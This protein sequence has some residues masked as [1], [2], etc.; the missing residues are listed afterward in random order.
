MTEIDPSV[1]RRIATRIIESQFEDIEYLT[2]A[3][4]TSDMLDA[5]ELNL[6]QEEEEAAWHAVD[7]WISKADINIVFRED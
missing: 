6:T 1:L 3:E 5:E 4:M 7:A 2:V